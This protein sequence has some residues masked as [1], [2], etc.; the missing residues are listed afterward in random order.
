MLIVNRQ[1]P[2][3]EISLLIDAKCQLLSVEIFSE[4]KS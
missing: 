4:F 3:K 1:F 2:P